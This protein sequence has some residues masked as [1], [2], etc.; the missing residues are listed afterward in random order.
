MGEMILLMGHG[1]RDPDGVEEFRDL[2]AAVRAA[3]PRGWAIAAGVLEFAQP[4]VPS[5]Q[6]AIDRCVADGAD[7]IL[8]VPML[9]FNAGHAKED[10]PAQIARARIRHPGLN[11]RLIRPLGMHH[12]LLE[13]AEERLSDLDRQL[14]PGRLDETAVLLV[15]RGTS[16]AV[17]NGD[18]FKIGRLIWERNRYGLVE[19]GFAG[20]A[21]PL[22][23]AGI[24][25]C[26]RLGARRILV[27]PYFINTGTLVKR[28][29]S[30]ARAAQAVYPGVEIVSGAHFGV[31]PKLVQ[32]LLTR[33]EARA[34][35]IDEP[36][37][38]AIGS[39]WR[40]ARVKHHRHD[41]DT[42]HPDDIRP[43]LEPVE[44]VTE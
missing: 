37:D 42:H 5:I 18:F 10:M 21:E 24:E 33:S 32:L 26:V 28:I 14:A 16:D 1:S 29:H 27:L 30:Q 38:G 7:R 12:A 39:P 44:V 40:Y 17:A 3:A 4:R 23:P 9:L 6:E 43:M 25:R 2:V 15:G 11:L 36:D 35:G 13:L 31:H 41:A 19:C 22:V 8:A 20:T 34:G